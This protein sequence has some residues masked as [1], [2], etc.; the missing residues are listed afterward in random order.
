MAAADTITMLV[1]T[2]CHL[3]YAEKDSIRHDDS[4]KTFEEILQLAKSN[5]VSNTP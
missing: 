5:D 3:G 1:A 4:F 2:D